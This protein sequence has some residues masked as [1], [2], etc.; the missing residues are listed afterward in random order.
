M[1][2]WHF[3]TMGFFL[4]VE[5]WQQSGVGNANTGD[6]NNHTEANRIVT[7]FMA[8]VFCSQAGDFVLGPDFT[9]AVLGKLERALTARFYCF[10]ALQIFGP[11]VS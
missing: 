2:F 9:P 5:Y 8:F 7:L 10:D 11:A 6:A 3:G 4:N 1:M